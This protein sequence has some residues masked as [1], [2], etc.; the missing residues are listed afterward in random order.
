LTKRRKSKSISGF[1]LPLY[2]LSQFKSK[3]ITIHSTHKSGRTLALCLSSWLAI[4]LL[5]ASAQY[6]P[7]TLKE[8]L[9]GAE[10]A[11][12]AAPRDAKKRYE[13]ADCLRKSGDLHT[14]AI[15]YLEVTVLDPTYYVAYHQLLDCKPTD[16]QLDE[17]IERLTKLEDQRPKEL[18]LRVAL[19]EVLEKRGETY[20][21]ARALVD[22]QFAEYIPPKYTTQINARVRY[23]L[24][25]SRDVQTTEKANQATQPASEDL[26]SVPL[27]IPE[28]TG[29]KD[30]STAK[31]KDSG[32][33][34][35]YGHTKLLP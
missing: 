2:N 25:K 9:K 33:T 21:A 17:A 13:W 28:N 23:L 20:K 32:E 35:G 15:E 31:L 4:S 1:H 27:P 34:E 5:P 7:P 16:D 14:A 12:Q 8:L 29:A 6:R 3:L 26:D 22:L 10:Q 19:S 30:F 18:M 11:A 24:G